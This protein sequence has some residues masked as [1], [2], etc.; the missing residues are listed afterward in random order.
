MTSIKVQALATFIAKFTN[1][2]EVMEAMEPV[3]PHT[4]SLF[5]YGSF[6]E[7]G[8]RAEVI[9]ESPESHK[10]NCSVRFRFKAFNDVTEYQALLAGLKLAKEMQTNMLFICSDYQLVVS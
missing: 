6:G 7:E 9:L 8:S 10:L 5:V 3:E 2:P 1:V 4:W